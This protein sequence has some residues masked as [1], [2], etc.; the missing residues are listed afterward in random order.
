MTNVLYKDNHV[1]VAYK[2]QNILQE[3]LIEEIKKEM[4]KEN[5]KTSFM[6][7]I[8]VLSVEAGGIVVLALTS[9]AKERLLKQAE[10]GDF[11]LKNF[12]VCVGKPKF[13][14]RFIFSDEEEKNYQ[15]L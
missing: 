9:K 6:E 1:L 7:P 11:I 15:Y 2:E 5:Q 10:D 4:E 13:A 3:S 12:A 8:N 14:A